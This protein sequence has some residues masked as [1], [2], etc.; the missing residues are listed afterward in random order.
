[1][2]KVVRTAAPTKLLA[3]CDEWTADFLAEVRRNHGYKGMSKTIRDRYNQPEIR[4]ALKAMYNGKCCYCE[5]KIGKEAAE[6]IEHFKPKSNPK[7]HFLA[8][9]WENLHWCCARCNQIKGS[10]WNSHY[11]IVDPTKENPDYHVKLNVI[12]GELEALSRR[13]KHT[14]EHPNLNRE[15]LVDAR[16]AIIH[17]L[18]LMQLMVL[19]TPTKKD[20]VY[21]KQLL[22]TYIDEGA[23]FSHL[24]EQYIKQWQL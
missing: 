21:F 12:T 3:K 7:F 18:N 20:D 5:N 10:K 11:P 4:E 8:F 14:I 16:K 19:N 17:R 23:E 1:M 15:E 9:K 6:N 13:G 2:K 24:M 22:Q